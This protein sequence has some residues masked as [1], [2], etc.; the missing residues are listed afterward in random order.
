CLIDRPDPLPW[1]TPAFA[2]PVEQAENEARSSVYDDLYSLGAVIYLL[3]T[4]RA[5]EATALVPMQK[6]RRG[7]PAEIQ[8][9]VADLLL[10]PPRQRPDA[11]NV[12][13][14]LK[15]TLAGFKSLEA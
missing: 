14:R 11:Q 7:I 1:G 10:A 3:F 6:L 2:P 8:E 13:Q 12:A 15:A 4:G 5:P 9:I